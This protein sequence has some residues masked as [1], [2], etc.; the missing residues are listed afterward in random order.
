MGMGQFLVISPG[1]I[2]TILSKGWNEA[3]GRVY[4]RRCGGTVR[5]GGLGVKRCGGRVRIGGLGVE[6]WG[7]GG[8]DGVGVVGG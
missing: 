4:V 5:I 3:W 1:I 8:G 7:G 2:W 6:E